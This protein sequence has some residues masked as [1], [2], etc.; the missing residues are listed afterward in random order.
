MPVMQNTL[1]GENS[2]LDITEVIVSET[3]D[4]A[5]NTSLS[6]TK[7]K[8]TGKNE[9]RLAPEL[10]ENFKLPH[11]HLIRILKGWSGGDKN[12]GRS[13]CHFFPIFNGNSK[14]TETQIT[15]R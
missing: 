3:E 15:Q 4:I 8:K 13:N 12:Y 5:I 14:P 7:R 11:L 10:W 9:Q 6:E 1:N 2:R